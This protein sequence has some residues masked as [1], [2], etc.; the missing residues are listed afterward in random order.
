MKSAWHLSHLVGQASQ[1][2]KTIRKA[3]WPMER[4]VRVTPSETELLWL[5]IDGPASCHSLCLVIELNSIALLSNYENSSLDTLLPAMARALQPR[6][7]RW[8]QSEF[9]NL[10]YIGEACDTRLLYS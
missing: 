3:E 10:G 2:R 4:T 7:Q 6:A 1:P 5:A 9:R 8:R